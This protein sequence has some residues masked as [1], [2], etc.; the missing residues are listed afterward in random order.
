[1][2]WKKEIMMRRSRYELRISTKLVLEFIGLSRQSGILSISQANRPPWPVTGIT[3][4]FFYFTHGTFILKILLYIYVDCEVSLSHSAP[5]KDVL[6]QGIRK[7]MVRFQKLLTNLF[8]NLHGHN[9]HVSSGTCPSFSCVHYNPSILG[10][11]DNHPYGN[12]THPTLGVHVRCNGL[13]CMR[14]PITKFVDGHG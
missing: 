6:I 12:H 3:L 1:M 8:F 2:I 10:S 5:S 7:R 4:L 9:I 14:Y 13:Q 11:Y